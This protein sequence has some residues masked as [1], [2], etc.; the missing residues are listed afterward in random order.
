MLSLASVRTC[1]ASQG[2]ADRQFSDRY[3]NNHIK[4]C[5]VWTGQDT[6]GRYVS[7]YSFN[8]RTAGCT[9]PLLQMKNE[10]DLRPQYAQ[11]VNLD[12]S[13]IEGTDDN[14]MMQHQSRNRTREQYEKQHI[15]GSFGNVDGTVKVPCQRN[16]DTVAQQQLNRVEQF[17]RVNHKN[18][19]YKRASGISGLLS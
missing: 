16:T 2:E 3:F 7:S 5:P 18:S 13:G 6:A 4:V 12:A 14:T 19:A 17:Y 8:N 15:G 1:K 11:Y 10:N 9:P